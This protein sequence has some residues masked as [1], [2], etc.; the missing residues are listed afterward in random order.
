MGAMINNGT[1]TLLASLKERSGAVHGVRARQWASLNFLNFMESLKA[2][3]RLTK[4]PRL[5]WLTIYRVR[6]SSFI[7]RGNN[8]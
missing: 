5:L 6:P 4:K 7:E 3:G 8:Y 1:T 2:R